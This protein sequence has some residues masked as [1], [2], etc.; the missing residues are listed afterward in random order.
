MTE[1]YHR[2]VVC[3]LIGHDL[4]VPLDVELLLPGEGEETAAKRLLER[5]FA[6]YRRFFD[7]VV[8]DALYLDAPFMNFCREHGKHAIVTIRGDHR[9]L[10]QDAQGLFRQQDPGEWTEGNC[11]VQFWDVEG[12]TSCEGVKEPLR[13]LHAVETTHRRQ[14]IARQ[15]QEIEDTKSWYWATTLS[16][17]QLSTRRLWRA[18]HGRWDI[19]N[20]CFNTLSTHWGL[21]HCYKHDPTAIVNLT[22][23]LFIVF[24]LLAVLLAPQSEASATR[25]AYPH[26]AGPRTGPHARRLPGAV[27]SPTSPRSV[28]G[29]CSVRPASAPLVTPSRVLGVSLP[30]SRPE[31]E[32]RLSK[33]PPLASLASNDTQSMATNHLPAI[34]T[35]PNWPSCGIADGDPPGLNPTGLLVTMA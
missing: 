14:R 5:V 13:V 15:W 33:L 19:E 12:F 24:V 11:R 27:V 9:L 21:D 28:S 1:Y 25:P 31:A 23:T 26:R 35:N 22:L 6:L 3:H 10:L 17:R 18:G 30:F 34:P 20:D 2:G 4:A 8:G 32:K 16:P 29:A 7:V